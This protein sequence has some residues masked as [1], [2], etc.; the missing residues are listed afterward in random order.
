MKLDHAGR[1]RNDF[2]GL[3][4]YYVIIL[5]LIFIFDRKFKTKKLDMKLLVENIYIFE[6][7]LLKKQ[8]FLVF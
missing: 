8:L 4:Y 2:V 1:G 3:M 6:K 5:Y 7:L